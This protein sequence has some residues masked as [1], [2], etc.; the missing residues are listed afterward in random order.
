MTPST[1]HTSPSTIHAAIVKALR[2]IHGCTLEGAGLS[3]RHLTEA[4]TELLIDPDWYSQDAVLAWEAALT[5]AQ[6]QS[7]L[8]QAMRGTVLR[9]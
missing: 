7:I 3:D 2:F 8:Q 4:V 5:A 1:P 9:G 6:R